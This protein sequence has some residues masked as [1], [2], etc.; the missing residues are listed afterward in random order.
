MADNNNN[1]NSE[2]EKTASQNESQG[3]RQLSYQLSFSDFWQICKLSSKINPYFFTC[4]ILFILVFVVI[5]LG[6]IA[7]AV[8]PDYIFPNSSNIKAF[9][10]IRILSCFGFAVKFFLN[11][12][13]WR[14]PFSLINFNGVWIG[15]DQFSAKDEKIHQRLVLKRV[16]QDLNRISITVEYADKYALSP[17][18]PVN[19]GELVKKYIATSFNIEVTEESIYI[20]YS[21]V[22]GKDSYFGSSVGLV[23]DGNGFADSSKDE[24]ANSVQ[25][26]NKYLRV[27]SFDERNEKG[28]ST[29][30][31]IHGNPKLPQEECLNTVKELLGLRGLNPDNF[32][33][34]KKQDSRDLQK[35][36]KMIESY[37]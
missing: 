27:I 23:S 20:Y 1:S 26:K 11:K 17:L 31:R 18:R 10:T 34:T 16:Q 33:D 30:V 5:A 19:N 25:F 3:N 6:A 2:S 8:N 7:V 24:P 12:F 13:L 32:A 28:A 37:R 36:F 35:A 22:M 29:F 4:L 14:I 15:V 9:G 21:Y